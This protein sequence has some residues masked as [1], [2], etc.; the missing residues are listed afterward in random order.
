MYLP[1]TE[2]NKKIVETFGEAVFN[3]EDGTINRKVL[4]ALVF[5]E[6][7]KHNMKRLTDIVWPGIYSLAQQEISRLRSEGVAKVVLVEAAVL[8]EAGWGDLVDELWVLYVEEEVACE[9]LMKRNSLSREECL[10]RIQSQL[11]NE[12]R[13]AAATIKIDAGGAEETVREKVSAEYLRLLA[14]V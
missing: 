6:D 12:A 11:S 4:G 10:K 14:R 7:N 13:L 8:V 3:P 9:R 5:G 1:G 2:G